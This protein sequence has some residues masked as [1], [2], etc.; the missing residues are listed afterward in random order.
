MQSS[1]GLSVGTLPDS[2][3]P[4]QKRKLQ[5][6]QKESSN[7][8]RPKSATASAHSPTPPSKRMKI[9]TPTE[10]SRQSSETSRSM[11][12]TSRHTVIDLTR[13]SNFQ[14]HSGAKRLVVKNFRPTPPQGVVDYYNKIWADIDI[15]LTSI[16]NGQQTRSPLEVLCRSVEATCRRGKAQMLFEHLKDRSKAYLE[17]QL[18]PAMQKEVGTTSVDALRTVYRFW[19]LWNRQS[20][21]A[22]AP[23]GAVH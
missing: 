19:T 9:P 13:P 1:A 22:S 14:P 12:V 18:L 16:Y 11:G 3:N 17:K 4:S 5:G 6:Q 20:V 15:A 2:L 23:I 21:S 7:T 8:P 10:S